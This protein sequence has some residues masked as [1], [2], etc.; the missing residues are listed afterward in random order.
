MFSTMCMGLLEF[1]MGFCTES[2]DVFNIT[3]Y[4]QQD[5]VCCELQ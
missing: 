3:D 1:I 5:V 4:H 2:K